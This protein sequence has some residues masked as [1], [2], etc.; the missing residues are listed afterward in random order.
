MDTT[1]IFY[2]HNRQVCSVKTKTTIHSVIIICR[3]IFGQVRNLVGGRVRLIIA[4]GAPLTAE[5][6]EVVKICVCTTLAQGYGLT[7][8]TSSTSV[9]DGKEHR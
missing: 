7:E 1:W 6:Q 3:I 5:T 4:G 8:T 2:S 9:Q